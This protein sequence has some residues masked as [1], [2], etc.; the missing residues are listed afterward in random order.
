MDSAAQLS[1]LL[2]ARQGMTQTAVNLGIVKQQNEAAQAMAAMVQQLSENASA[3][4]AEAVQSI[5]SDGLGQQVNLL[6]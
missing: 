5:R 4:G 3:L 2:A 6:A 1:T